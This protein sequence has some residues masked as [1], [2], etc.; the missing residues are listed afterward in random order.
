MNSLSKENIAKIIEVYQRFAD[1]EGFA[2]IVSL[3]DI[4]ENDYNLNVPLYVMPIEEME[5]I[6][7]AK[8]LSELRQL[9]KERQEATDRVKKYISDIV[10][11]IGEQH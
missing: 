1:E 10:Q 3:E 2:K 9:E 6:D 4:A 11:V 5:E 8:E 7:L